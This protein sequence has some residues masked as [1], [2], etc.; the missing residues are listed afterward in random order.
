MAIY[1]YKCT[2]SCEDIVTKVRSI[3]EEDPGYNCDICDLPLERLFSK[4]GVIF[5]GSGFYSTDN[6]K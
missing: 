6:K 3:K 4:P 5:N 2:G 1:E